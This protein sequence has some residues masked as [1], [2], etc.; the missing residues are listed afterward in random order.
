MDFSLI[1]RKAVPD[2]AQAIQDIMKEA[3]EKYK[4][5]IKLEGSMEALEESLEDIK[6]DIETKEVFVAFI[7]GNAVASIRVE[8]LP[9]KTA[10]ISRFGV[11]LQYHNM[12]IGKAMMSI[13]DE[14]L[15]SKGVK[16][17]YLHTASK[18]KA[19]V[20]FYY[21]RDFYVHSTSEEKGY[22]RAL[23]VKDY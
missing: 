11:K 5:D 3:F 1:I 21:G 18:Y 23:M 2:D 8:I 7:D 19:L 20:R 4:S 14:L 17:A 16:K 12:G 15:I 6:K 9:D 10:Y 22:I 13:V